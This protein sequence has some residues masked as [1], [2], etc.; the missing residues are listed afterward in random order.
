MV[1]TCSLYDL[2]GAEG[3]F[4]ITCA[5]FRIYAYCESFRWVHQYKMTTTTPHHLTSTLTTFRNKKHTHTKELIASPGQMRR[6]PKRLPQLRKTPIGLRAKRANRHCRKKTRHSRR[7]NYRHQA[8][9]Y[10]SLLRPMQRV[11][12][13]VLW[14]TTKVQP[15][16]PAPDVVRVRC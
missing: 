11:K 2:S 14:R 7:T 10:I 1:G 5:F 12:G 15:L 13:K 8:E 4:L 3:M 6:A 9:A 16:L